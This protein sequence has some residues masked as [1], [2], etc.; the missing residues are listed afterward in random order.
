MPGS[1][2]CI[3]SCPLNISLGP[4]DHSSLPFDGKKHTDIYI[5]SFYKR[6]SAPWQ[7]GQ[8]IVLSLRFPLPLVRWG[9]CS[10]GAV[11]VVI[12][13]SRFILGALFSCRSRGLIGWDSRDP[14]TRTRAFLAALSHPRGEA[15][16]GTILC[17]CCVRRF[18]LLCC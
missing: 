11:P 12:A 3:G 2:R 1:E 18:V 4:N 17:L 15:G 5:Q 16:P 7:S 14:I 10:C 8:R 6:S 9:W 13:S